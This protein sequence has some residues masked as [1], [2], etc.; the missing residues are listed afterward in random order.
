MRLFT[1]LAGILLQKTTQSKTLTKAQL[2]FS[3]NDTRISGSCISGK[4]QH[5]VS[6]FFF[7]NVKHSEFTGFSTMHVFF[8]N[9]KLCFLQHFLNILS[10]QKIFS[11][12]LIIFYGNPAMV[13][14]NFSIR[15]IV[16]VTVKRRF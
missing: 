4:R 16:L 2:K 3:K 15:K 13:I 5:D 8:I 9:V 14:R 10:R 12:R 6:V 7:Q 1:F 11:D